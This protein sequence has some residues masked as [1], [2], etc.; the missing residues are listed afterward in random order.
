M[1]TNA[2]TSIATFNGISI[3]PTKLIFHLNYLINLLRLIFYFD[4]EHLC[5]PF[6]ETKIGAP[7][8]V[9][10][11]YLLVPPLDTHSALEHPIEVVR[12]VVVLVHLLVGLV[13]LKVEELGQLAVV[14][15]FQRKPLILK[16]RL[17]LQEVCQIFG[18][19]FRPIIRLH[20]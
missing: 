7:G 12:L 8:L 17:L 18:L 9:P 16:H 5:L 11:A 10:V 3:F 13:P 19:L 1:I 20:I 14:L 4:V 2:I 15:V 6:E